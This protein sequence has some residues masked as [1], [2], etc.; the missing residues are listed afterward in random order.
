MRFSAMS[1]P[2]AQS[3]VH[4]TI[5][6]DDK[7]Q[8]IDDCESHEI[9]TDDKDDII[10]IRDSLDAA[11]LDSE[12]SFEEIE[13]NDGAKEG[14]E[15]GNEVDIEDDDTDGGC[16]SSRINDRGEKLIK[17]AGKLIKDY[18][19]PRNDPEEVSKL[20]ISSDSLY[21]QMDSKVRGRCLIFNNE[22]FESLNANRPRL[23]PRPGTNIDKDLLKTT[24]K[25]L[26]FRIKVYNNK[27][28]EE[29]KTIVNKEAVKD[30]SEMDCFVCCILSH[31]T[32]EMLSG[33][34]GTKHSD[35]NYFLENVIDPFLGENC[36]SLA[37]KPKIFIVNACRGDD[38]GFE[39]V[40][41]KHRNEE[42]DGGCSTGPEAA[43]SGYSTYRIPTYSD[44]LVARSCFDG[45]VSNRNPKD[46]SVFVRTLCEVLRDYHQRF[47]FLQMLT[48]VNQKVAYK[49]P[50]KTEKDGGDCE[51]ASCG[52]KQMPTVMHTLTRMIKFPSKELQVP[53]KN[54]ENGRGDC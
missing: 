40:F 9:S 35:G 50:P 43:E 25:S 4:D 34:Y 3:Y 41:V 38:R 49:Y 19:D 29:V 18:L 36:P 21:Y 27:T 5:T 45:F 1:N 26:K 28:A 23:S 42:A 13:T 54:S 46:G 8:D 15:S 7:I 17:A 12:D 24:F 44:I 2:S 20:E 30:F 11:N 14:G 32:K 51:N 33:K 10:K 53:D 47:D 16:S 52:R 22:T 48:I 6:F 37:G 31:G 39:G